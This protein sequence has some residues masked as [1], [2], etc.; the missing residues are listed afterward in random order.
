M[1]HKCTL[2]SNSS[3]SQTSLFKEKLIV[4]SLITYH[5]EEHQNLLFVAAWIGEIYFRNGKVH[6]C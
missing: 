1:I 4:Y 5:D 6:E 2:K 3:Q